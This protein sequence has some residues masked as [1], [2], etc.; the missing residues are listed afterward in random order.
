MPRGRQLL[1]SNAIF[2]L[3]KVKSSFN[4]LAGRCV[5]FACVAAMTLGA[6]ACGSKRPN[7]AVVRGMV[8]VDGVPLSTGQ[9]E[10]HPKSGERPARSVINADG[11]YQLTTFNRADG[12]ILGAHRVTITATKTIGP[13]PP[14]SIQDEA[15]QGAAG[16]PRLVWLVSE[17]YSDAATTDLI[18]DVKD[19]ENR[20]D[21]NVPK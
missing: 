14:A 13:S 19:G 10:F 12:A 7:T 2:R 6:G 3:T 15:K 17:K 16:Q 4:F 18:A 8:K 11:T 20:I 5:L 21:F 9:I 1:L